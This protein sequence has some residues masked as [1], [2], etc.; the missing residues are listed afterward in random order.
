MGFLDFFTGDTPPLIKEAIDN[1]QAML[2][3]GRD[4]FAA[5]A[6]HLLDNEILEVDLLALDR[7]INQREQTL[8]RV[9]LEHLTIDPKRELVLC[10][11][12]ISIV[13]EAERIGDLAKMLGRAA[14]L[15]QKP[16]MGP[17]VEPLRVIR[18]RILRMFDQTRDGF[19][20]GDASVAQHLMEEQPKIKADLTQYVRLLAD[21][22]DVTPNEAVV[23]TLS[24]RTMSRVSSHLANIAS[25]VTS[26]FDQIRRGT[27]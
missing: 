24:A 12:L 14:R 18:S 23:Y 8:R 16:R 7:D 15:A 6:A 19:V 9:V 27:V 5:A 20:E 11:K 1:V 13:Q 4:M 25:T 2:N 17:H 3:N 22:A 10:L 21:D 26:P